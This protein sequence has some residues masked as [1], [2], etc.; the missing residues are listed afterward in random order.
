MP[1][2]RE[3]CWWEE[4]HKSYLVPHPQTEFKKLGKDGGVG[5]PDVRRVLFE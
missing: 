1:S 5:G 3:T 4:F 2:H